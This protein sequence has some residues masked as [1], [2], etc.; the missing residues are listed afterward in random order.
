MSPVV[1]RSIAY[2]STL[3]FQLVDLFAGRRV[4]VLAEI[5]FGCA[6]MGRLTRKQRM[7]M[8]LTYI[9]PTY[10]TNRSYLVH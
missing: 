7:T 9:R 5:R 6:C 3:F 4:D 10:L 8:V 1:G 2:G